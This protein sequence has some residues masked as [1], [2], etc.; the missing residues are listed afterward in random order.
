MHNNFARVNKH[1]LLIEDSLHDVIMDWYKKRNNQ[2]F[3]NVFPVYMYKPIT[4]NI[5]AYSVHT[6]V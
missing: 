4:F 3:E 2:Y 1:K 6:E 5:S